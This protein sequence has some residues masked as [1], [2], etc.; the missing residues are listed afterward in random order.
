VHQQYRDTFLLFQ[1]DAHNYKIIG[2]LKQLKL[3]LSL[4]HVSVHAGTIIRVLS[5]PCTAHLHNRQVCRHDIDHVSNDEHNRI[6]FLVLAK[7]EIAPW[8]WLLRKPKHVGAIVEIL[9]VLIFP[10]FYNCVHQF[11]IIKKCLDTR[12]KF[13]FKLDASEVKKY[14]RYINWDKICALLGYYAE[15]W[16]THK[17]IQCR[18]ELSRYL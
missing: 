11:G 15:A 8:R 1:T 3:R 14:L 13:D 12:F 2:I 18:Y 10:W 4:E 6:I 16:I 17:T 9:I 7:H 5:P